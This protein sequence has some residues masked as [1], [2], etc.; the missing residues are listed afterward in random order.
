MGSGWRVERGCASSVL[1]VVVTFVAYVA[2]MRGEGHGDGML[3]L[4]NHLVGHRASATHCLAYPIVRLAEWLSQASGIGL[5]HAAAAGSALGMAIGVGFAHAAWR[6]LGFG[7]V[8]AAGATLVLACC[9]SVVLYGTVYELHGVFFAFAGA[10]FRVM[11]T[12]VMRPSAWRAVGMGGCAALSYLAHATGALWLGALVLCGGAAAADRRGGWQAL[13]VEVPRAALALATGVATIFAALALARWNGAIAS[14]AN[15]AR[16]AVSWSDSL[17]SEFAPA[18]GHPA[19]TVWRE[20]LL[21]FFPVSLLWLAAWRGGRA[22]C[23]TV[24]LGLSLPVYV[25][26]SWGLLGDIDEEGAY[27][28]PLAL[29]AVWLART[30]LRGPVPAVIM[31]A[32]GLAVLPTAWPQ[33]RAD[34]LQ[35]EGAELAELAAGNAIFLMAHHADLEPLLLGAPHAEWFP[36]RAFTAAKPDA[37]RALEPWTVANLRR[38]IGEGCDVVITARGRELLR[39][40]WWPENNPGAPVVAETLHRH[41]RFEDVGGTAIAAY[42]LVPRRL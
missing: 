19:G 3:Y 26:V 41:F 12:Y 40:D 35:T 11:A 20:W 5:Y 14:V 21:P 33:R 42:R 36:L 8:E 25:G 28:L 37:A 31:A 17:P 38:M 27:L 22:R 29:P 10:S 23:L 16:V 6:R 2:A 24:A 13:G 39:G 15:A 7:G 4:Y 1:V 18:I 30:A 34:T 32:S 9:P